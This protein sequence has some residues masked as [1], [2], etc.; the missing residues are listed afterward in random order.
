[1][2][3]KMKAL[4]E[5]QKKMQEV[6]HQLDSTDFDIQS[7]DGLVKVV[8]NASQEIKEIIIKDNFSD[9][10]KARLAVSIKD[11]LNRAI[12]RSQDIAAKKMKEVTGL[13]IPGLT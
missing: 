1:M 13:N 11:T 8:M 3:D 4:F 10:E 9:A 6:K 2:F 5:M 7:P 12:K